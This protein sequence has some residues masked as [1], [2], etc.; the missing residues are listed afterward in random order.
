[1]SELHEKIKASVEGYF[2]AFND[3]DAEAVIR[4]FADDASVE[5]PVGTPIRKGREALLEFYKGSMAANAQLE[6][7]G[8]V[9][10]AG[11]EAAFPFKAVVDMPDGRIEASV[12]DVMEFDEEGKIRKM[13]A[14]FGDSN[15]RTLSKGA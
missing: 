3:L 15:I 10:I 14:F 13:R 6:P 1:M 7:T 9:R 5:D 11:K 2:Q 12:I 4:L 8:P